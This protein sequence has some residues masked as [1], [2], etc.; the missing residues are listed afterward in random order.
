M[1]LTNLSGLF[2]LLYGPNGAKVEGQIQ[3][4]LDAYLNL[5][6]AGIMDSS[7]VKSQMQ[8]LM[9]CGFD[10]YWVKNKGDTRIRTGE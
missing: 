9:G 8:G 10:D 6:Q 7:V 4:K 1:A 2:S 3:G 5:Y